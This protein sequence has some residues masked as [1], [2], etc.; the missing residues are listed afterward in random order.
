V[1]TKSKEHA[2]RIARD[3]TG[4]PPIMHTRV[5]SNQRPHYHPS[6]GGDPLEPHVMW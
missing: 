6:Q 1:L 3:V 4:E 2:F 5:P